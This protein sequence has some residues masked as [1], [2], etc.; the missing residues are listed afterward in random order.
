MY[1]TY[2][3]HQ[4]IIEKVKILIKNIF[5]INVFTKF[6]RATQDFSNFESYKT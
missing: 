2:L 1:S 5:D 6:I 3:L 4:L